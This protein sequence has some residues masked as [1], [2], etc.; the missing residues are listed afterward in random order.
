MGA[1]GSWLN[2]MFYNT[3][4]VEDRNGVLYN[5]DSASRNALGTTL[6]E[7]GHNLGLDHANYRYCEYV[8]VVNS[9]C[10]LRQ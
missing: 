10:V 9:E 3:S 8:P 6:H 7:L 4:T 1:K 2:G 5:A